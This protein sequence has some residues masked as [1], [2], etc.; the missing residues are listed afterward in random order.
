MGLFD[1]PWGDE[2]YQ[3]GEPPRPED[4]PSDVI[5]SAD[6]RFWED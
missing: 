6:T 5:V 2:K 3:G 1:N 4:K